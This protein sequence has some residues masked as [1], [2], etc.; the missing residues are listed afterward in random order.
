MYE[1]LSK[2]TTF[3]C[4]L[5]L[6]VCLLGMFLVNSI[7]SEPAVIEE[8][9]D[10]IDELYTNYDWDKLSGDLVK[11]YQ[12]DNYTSIFGID[13]AAHQDVID[14]KQVKEA[15][16]EFAYIRLGYRG[17][18]EGILHVDEQFENNYAGALANGIKVGVYWYSQ[19]V[20]ELEAIAEADFVIDTLANRHLDLPI[21][22]DFEET[23]FANEYSRIHGM[24]KNDCTAMAIA[25]CNEMY[26]HNYETILYS[27]KYWA[28]ECYDWSIL[29][30]FNTWFAQ[31]DVDYPDFDK[32]MVIWQYSDNGY[33]PGIN[34]NCDL[35][36]M[37]MHNHDQN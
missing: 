19:P 6:S 23:E 16:V 29:K 4:L 1:R 7:T 20:S 11:T 22:Y 9:N 26:R 35:N 14:W 17:A 28:D 8:D 15:G 25:F 21:A 37:F 13:V 27:N 34:R 3:I 33:I 12:D 5:L 10:Q 30:R 24:S 32:P 2:S 18:L 36:I 31:Y